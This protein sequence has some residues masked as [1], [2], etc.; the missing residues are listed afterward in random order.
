[1]INLK[2]VVANS[3]QLFSRSFV[4]YDFYITSKRV[5]TVFISRNLEMITTAL[6]GA[7]AAILNE[8]YP[9]IQFI[10]FRKD[11]KLCVIEKM[12]VTDGKAR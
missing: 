6:F 10:Q 12:G 7:D 8:F 3:Q 11:L 5:G 4:L 2:T 9:V 1:M